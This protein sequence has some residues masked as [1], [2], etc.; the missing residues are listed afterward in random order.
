V[1]AVYH[2]APMKYHSH[3]SPGHP[4]TRESAKAYEP[5]IV[6][7]CSILAQPGSP[8]SRLARNSVVL[9]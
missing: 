5:T 7:L 8:N 6:A 1:H 2:V 9:S 3:N 4:V